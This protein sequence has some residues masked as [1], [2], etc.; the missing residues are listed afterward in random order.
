MR[1][2]KNFVSDYIDVKDIDTKELAEKMVFAGN[3][4]ESIEKTVNASGCVIGKVLECVDHE[5]SD[6]LHICKVDY[7]EGIKQIVCGAPNVKEGIKVIVAKVGAILGDIEIK[8]ATLAGVE[9]EGMLCALD[10]LGVDKKYLKEDEVRGI[11]I[12]D[13]NA[14]IGEDAIKYLGIDDEVIDFELTANRAD[15]LSVLGMAYE[16]GAIY[17]KKV[18]LPEINYEEIDENINDLIK[19]E[20]KTDSCKAYMGKIVKDVTIKESPDFI[21]NRLIASGIRPINN[22]V[23]ISNYVMLE[24]GQPMHFFDKDLL[25]DVVIVRDAEDG[26]KLTTLD[27]IERTLTSDDI[28]IANNKESL[29]L[30][31]VMGGLSTEVTNNTKNVFIESA[32]FDSVKVRRTSSKIVRSESSNRFEKGIDPNRVKFA[33]DRAVTLLS[34][35]ADAKVVK[36]TVSYDK[37]NKEDKIIDVTLTRINNVLG[38]NLT[39]EDVKDVFN[40]LEF[41]YDEKDGNFKV[42]VPT[43]RLDVNIECDIFEEVGR[44]YGYDKLEGKKPVLPV[45]KG[46]YSKLQKYINNLED[47]LISLGLNQVR[48]YSLVNEKQSEMFLFRNFD[49]IEILSPLS[50]DRKILRRS[51]I[52]S[53]IE[54][55]NYNKARN[56]DY[57]NIF[58]ASV[59]NYKIDGEYIEENMISGLISSNLIESSWNANKKIDFYTL[60]G[61]V[62]NLLD[63]IGLSGRY[64]FDTENLVKELHPYQSAYIKVDNEVVG[65]LG[66]VHPSTVKKDVYVFELSI[67]KLRSKKVRNIKYKEI[68]KYPSITKDV[69]FITKKDVNSSFIENNIKK[70]SGRLLTDIKVFDVYTGENVSEDEKSIAYKLTYSDLNRT[71]S[72]EEVNTLFYKMIDAVEKKCNV[73]LRNE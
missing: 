61:I 32:I 30:A 40:R 50:E 62:T 36:D 34:K 15:L 8:K 43:R 17:N 35:Y 66:K 24:T 10:E 28:V 31:G 19:L 48:T 16:L 27:N 69:A 6:H 64:T 49:K 68:S 5:K 45:K 12:L 54:V 53:L 65:Y 47:R 73:K 33:L 57:V 14:P 9:S 42:Y 1:L 25:G 58:E 46:G 26:E 51:L 72:D 71:L 41:K 23:D 18:K 59:V 44:I 67:D 29:C 2:S 39:I 37:T 63:Y 52:P 56:V 3:E 4:Y 20:V 22:V 60:K 11:H 38:M 55:Y 7:G 70:A 21:K 13:D